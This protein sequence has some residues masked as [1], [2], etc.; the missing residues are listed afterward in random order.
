MNRTPTR[1]AEP[2]SGVWGRLRFLGPGF[3]LSASVVGSGE[4]IATTVLGARAGFAALW[5]ILL[6]CLVKVAVQVEFG[7]HAIISGLT[8]MA[9][10]QR[11]PGPRAGRGHWSVW[12]V[13]ILMSLKV[14]Q[15]GGILGSTAL[16]LHLLVPAASPVLFVLITAVLTSVLISKGRYRQIERLSLVMVASFTVLTLIALVAVQFTEF[17]FSWSDVTAAQGLRFDPAIAA[18]AVGAFGI[19][20]VGSDEIIAYNYWCLEKGYASRAGDQDG[21]EAWKRRAKGWISVMHLDATLAMVIYTL[22]TAAFYLLGASILH[23]TGPIPDGT[24]VIERLASI[25]T[26]SLGPEVRLVYLAGAF[27]VLFSSVLATLALWTRLFTD[28]GLQLRWIPYTHQPAWML[29]FAWLFPVCWALAYLFIGLPVLMVL[30]GGVVGSAVLLVVA[31]AAYRFHRKG[32]AMIPSRRVCT[33]FFWI[34]LLA[35]AGLALY[36]LYGVLG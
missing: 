2:P 26:E 23:G 34:S 3:I 22:V 10:F 17:A 8:P 6:S 25:Y 14:V 18:I 35:I 9:A 21:S 29:R 11:L 1:V 28:I 24:A 16:V 32:E 27:F 12:T 4:L 31:L 5:I 7:R 36:S 30:S 20:G 19:T 33:I 13:F 15:I